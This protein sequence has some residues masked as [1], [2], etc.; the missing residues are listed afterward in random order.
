M[1]KDES[2][3][4]EWCKHSR[5]SSYGKEGTNRR[6]RRKVK[7]VIQHTETHESVHIEDSSAYR[8]DSNIEHTKYTKPEP[9][10]GQYCIES[11]KHYK[12]WRIIERYDSK[13]KR[14]RILAELQHQERIKL[15]SWANT[16]HKGLQRYQSEFRAIDKPNK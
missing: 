5:N 13:T 11:N 15:L 2:G 8:T 12:K 3:T 14:D 9:K 7:A 10:T 4:S 16:Y 1:R 6:V